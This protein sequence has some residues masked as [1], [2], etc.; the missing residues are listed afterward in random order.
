MNIKVEP[1]MD[2]S[3]YT[4][5]EPWSILN[6]C[7]DIEERR[8]EKTGY[9]MSREQKYILTN[10]KKEEDGERQSVKMEREDVVKDE[11]GLWK[12]EEKES[13][14]EMGGHVAQTC[15]QEVEELSTLITSCLQKQPRVLIRRLEIASSSVPVL[16]PPCTMACKRDLGVRSPWRQ[17]ELLSLGENRSLRQKK[18]QVMTRRMKTNGQLERPPKML[19]SSSENRTGRSQ[20]PPSSTHEHL[21]PPT[22][23]QS[24]TGTPGAH[25]G[26]PG[27]HTCSQCG[28]SFTHLGDLKRHQIT[29][30]RERPYH[31]SQCGKSF[32][33]SINLKQ[34]QQIHTGESPYKCSHCGKCST[35]LAALKRHQGTH[36]GERPYH[37]SQCG[38]SFSQRSAW[39]LHQYIHT[40]ERPYHCT[41]CGRCFTQLFNLKRHQRIH[42]GERPFHCS[43]CG[44]SFGHSTTLKNHQRIHTGERPF[45][46]SQCGKSFGHSNTLKKHQRTHTGERPYQCPQCGKSFSRSASLKRHQRTHTG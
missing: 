20:Q 29:H 17:H 7:E 26:T 21:I 18:G 46:C 14:E 11:E 24:H 37:C 19:P 12:K 41:Q 32:T 4:G 43:Q 36:T 45:H 35:N 22:Q 28:K 25:T 15:K 5:V 27:A 33:H 38:K 3:D 42:T 23:T 39:K 13:D 6:K 31:C 40:G 44:K 16:L 30:T 10:M 34:H 1:V 8:E 9:F 2:S